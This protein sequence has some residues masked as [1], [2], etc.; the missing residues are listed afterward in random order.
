MEL[1]CLNRFLHSFRSVEMTVWAREAAVAISAAAV[2][3]VV[4]ASTRGLAG[5]PPAVRRALSA[6]P[7]SAANRLVVEAVVERPC[8]PALS[9][10][11]RC[12][13]S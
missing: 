6:C 2:L 7:A 13:C 8:G 10:W 3:P 11:G 9:Q 4:L 12:P 5:G 1:G